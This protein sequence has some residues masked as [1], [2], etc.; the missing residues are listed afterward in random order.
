VP[1]F[2]LNF[3]LVAICII[4]AAEVKKNFLYRILAITLLGVFTFNTVPREFI[5]QFLDHHDTRDTPHDITAFSEKHQHCA[6]FDIEPELYDIVTFTYHPLVKAIVWA[7]A[8]PFMPVIRYI[9][10]RDLS[11]RAPPVLAA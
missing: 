7:Y 10:F 8:S 3:N 11:L 4:F 5:H 6:Y 9:P 2:P 1:V